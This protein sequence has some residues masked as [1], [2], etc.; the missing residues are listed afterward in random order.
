M[1]PDWVRSLLD[2]CDAADSPFF[3]GRAAAPDR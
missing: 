1:H 3:Y 2:Q